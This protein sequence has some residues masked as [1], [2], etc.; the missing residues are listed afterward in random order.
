M[1]VL[2][3]FCQHFVD[4]MN[5]FT[6]LNFKVQRKYACSK[7]KPLNIYVDLWQH[8][9]I[10]FA[11]INLNISY[12]HRLFL[13]LFKFFVKNFRHTTKKYFQTEQDSRPFLRNH[14]SNHSFLLFGF[15]RVFN[16]IFWKAQFFC[17]FLILFKHF[18][19][20]YFKS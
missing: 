7:T 18:A 11:F 2:L 8:S 17:F 20:E 3:P 5:I 10:R 13:F 4:T 16:H 12:I 1:S 9:S 14:F 6:V 19:T 15:M